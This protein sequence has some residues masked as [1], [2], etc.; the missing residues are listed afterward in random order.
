MLPGSP[1]GTGARPLPPL[2]SR[3]GL[4]GDGDGSH[5][6]AVP[7]DEGQTWG[8]TWNLHTLLKPILSP[9]ES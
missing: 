6:T 7:G 8:Q 5:L 2:L 1:P 3:P 9:L 4:R